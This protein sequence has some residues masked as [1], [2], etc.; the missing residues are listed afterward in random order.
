MASIALTW[1][2]LL[3]KPGYLKSFNGE[4]LDLKEFLTVVHS[5]Y[6]MFNCE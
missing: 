1:K 2:V 4:V 6:Q 5:Q 3:C